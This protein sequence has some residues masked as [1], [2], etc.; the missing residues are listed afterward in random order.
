MNATLNYEFAC[1]FGTLGCFGE[2]SCGGFTIHSWVSTLVTSLRH[3]IQF[4]QTKHANIILVDKYYHQSLTAISLLKYLWSNRSPCKSD[5]SVRS[6][7]SRACHNTSSCK[8]E[9]PVFELK[10]FHIDGRLKF[11]RVG[12]EDSNCARYFNLSTFSKLM[13]MLWELFS[14]S[15]GD[16]MSTLETENKTMRNEKHLYSYRIKVHGEMPS[17]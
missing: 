1:H 15:W 10:C 17:Q 8:F 5:E 3:P 12:F 11:K 6:S 13:M 4:M 7:R 9:I 16:R 14:R 2:D